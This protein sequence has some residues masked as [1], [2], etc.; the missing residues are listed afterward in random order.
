MARNPRVTIKIEGLER[1]SKAIRMAGPAIHRAVQDAIRAAGA[2]AVA[3]ATLADAL[4]RKVEPVELSAEDVA[5][6]QI[7]EFQENEIRRQCGVPE[8]ISTLAAAI[9]FK[10]GIGFTTAYEILH[11]LNRMGVLEG[12][13]PR[14]VERYDPRQGAVLAQQGCNL[15]SP[16]LG[17]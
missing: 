14:D 12:I 13:S 15:C 10:P 11:E 5:F 3:E 4:D 16:T 17:I 7:R 2:Q 8:G 6:Q 9:R 1:M